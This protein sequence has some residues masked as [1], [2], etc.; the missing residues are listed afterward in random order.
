[1]GDFVEAVKPIERDINDI[2]MSLERH[3]LSCD[4]TEIV[5]AR[6]RALKTRVIPIAQFLTGP[7]KVDLVQR[8][9][10]LLQ[11][12]LISLAK[13]I[14]NILEA[15][16]EDFRDLPLDVGLALIEEV[17]HA[18]SKTGN[19]L[20]DYHG[21][22]LKI[23]INLMGMNTEY[24]EILRTTKCLEYILYVLCSLEIRNLT[25]EEALL[26][27][28]DVVL[29]AAEKDN[30]NKVL[31]SKFIIP[32][33]LGNL[34]QWPKDPSAKFIL[35]NLLFL[36]RETIS[37]LALCQEIFLENSGIEVLVRVLEEIDMTDL[38]DDYKSHPFDWAR[39]LFSSI[40]CLLDSAVSH[41]RKVCQ[42]AHE[43]EV[44][45]ILKG[46]LHV[47]PADQQGFLI[48]CCVHILEGGVPYP[49]IK[50]VND[51]Y[52]ILT[53]L[54]SKDRA[55]IPSADLQRFL[56][57]L[58]AES[59]S[60]RSEKSHNKKCGTPHPS[61]VKKIGL[62]M[63]KNMFPIDHPATDSCKDMLLSHLPN[64]V[65]P[66]AVQS[67]EKRKVK[68]FISYAELIVFTNCVRMYG[69]NM[70]AIRKVYPF[71]KDLTPGDLYAVWRAMWKKR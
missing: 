61:R 6:S 1:M 59:L 57:E 13:N 22:L 2:L 62:A 27:I 35:K 12:H 10:P 16:T 31:I 30:Q 54:S 67:P 50:M 9:R 26:S 25:D 66:A 3:L 14:G 52:N 58:L 34:S 49:D 69:I 44:L 23:I 60:V 51:M 71:H 55:L 64:E 11:H 33:V 41:N 5:I 42:K 47:T 7:Y 46:Y 37:N 18:I 65:K 4:G 21:I 19:I 39:T 36:S 24:H 63:S 29:L 17:K 32:M 8:L 28:V 48:A 40:V 68:F 70:R 15:L 56:L 43:M 45:F 20:S 38:M 53:Q